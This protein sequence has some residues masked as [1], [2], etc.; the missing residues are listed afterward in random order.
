MLVFRGVD[1]IVFL[2]AILGGWLM[3][4]VEPHFWYP[5]DPFSYRDSWHISYQKATPPI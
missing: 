5:D 4:V 3:L 1:R 2:Q